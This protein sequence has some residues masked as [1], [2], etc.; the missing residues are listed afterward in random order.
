LQVRELI[1]SNLTITRAAQEAGI[2]R[3]VMAGIYGYLR[4]PAQQLTIR[5]GSFVLPT[6]QRIRLEFHETRRRPEKIWVRWQK[7]YEAGLAGNHEAWPQIIEESRGL[8]SRLIKNLYLPGGEQEDLIQEGQIGIWKG[9]QDWKPVGGL[10]LYNFLKLAA[11][12]QL[13]DVIK[14]AGRQKHQPLNQALS[15]F[16]PVHDDDERLFIESLI[17]AGDSVWERIIQ[18]RSAGLAVLEQVNPDFLK[19]LSVIE[20]RALLGFLLEASYQEI[21]DCLGRSVKTVDNA[22]QRVRRAAKRLGPAAVILD[23]TK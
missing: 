4:D 22:L 14:I 20:R 12:R 13:L 5:H 19:S 10:S 23:L 8:V 18:K 9:L 16:D 1:A 17:G 11:K 3:K 21:A 6:L 15:L 2:G 7:L